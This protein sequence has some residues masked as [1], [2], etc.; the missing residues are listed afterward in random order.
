MSYNSPLERFFRRL[1]VDSWQYVKFKYR[2]TWRREG[3]E[4]VRV[5]SRPLSDLI[6]GAHTHPHLLFREAP[7]GSPIVDVS[8][9]FV[10]LDPPH[11]GAHKHPGRGRHKR[12][13]NEVLVL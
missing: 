13:H 8:E 10:P 6:G 12:P 11:T 7:S 2:P 9:I 3:T 4:G 1:D 5:L